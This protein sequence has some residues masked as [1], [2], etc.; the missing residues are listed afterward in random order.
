VR[1]ALCL[2]CLVL[3]GPA[4]AAIDD[5]QS[6]LKDLRSRIEQ[7]REALEQTSEDHAEVADALKQSEQQISTLNRTLRNLDTEEG[8]LNRELVRLQ[9]EA[10]KV[11]AE[12]RDHQ[13]RLAELL[14]Q[15]YYQG[16]EDS[17]RLMLSG[18]DPDEIQR[19]LY[20]FAYIGRARAEL[21]AAQRETL[22]RLAELEDKAEARK[23]RLADLR[24]ERLSQRQAL[25]G[26][27][28][29]RKTMLTRLSSQIHSQ[30]KEIKTLKQDE[31]RLARLLERL[32]KQAAAKQAA[33]KPAARPKPAG[34]PVGKV[35]SAALAGI[36]FPKLKGRLALPLGGEIIARF[37]Q[38]RE[39]GG[40]SWKG[41]YI[42]A[43]E[44][45]E[46]R[47]VATGEVVFA[48]WLRG[49]GNLLIVD[50]GDGYLSLYSNNE[51]LYKQPGDAVR[52]GDVVAAA[53]NTGGQE[54][55]GLYFELRHQGKPFDPLKWVA[56]G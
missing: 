42:R 51:S 55:P 27:K 2:L 19:N 22:G 17:L 36:D 40:P 29:A 53:G 33:A 50:H 31:A 45:Q 26:V 1:N 38:P 39:G 10:R 13:A 12:L 18:R 44:G 8:R 34:Q 21:I 5:K 30:R 4:L 52:A 16:G 41:L 35:A 48:D 23:V 11:E 7:L 28:S 3:A 20:Y 32:R 46:V 14:R 56:G 6:E 24:I 54:E 43:R 37:G 47:A 9:G 25:E 49:F 15:R